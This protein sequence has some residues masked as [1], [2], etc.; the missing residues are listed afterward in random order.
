MTALGIV[1]AL[2]LFM[3]LPVSAAS[4]LTITPSAGRNIFTGTGSDQ[5]RYGSS[6]IIND[7]R[8]IDVWFAAPGSAQ[9]FSCWDSVRYRRSTDGG[10]T[11]TA[12]KKVLEGTRNADDQYSTCDPGVVKFGGY[13][14]IGYTSVVKSNYDAYHNETGNQVYIARSQN[15]DGPYEKWNGNGW[16]GNSP[17]AF[18]TYP[19]PTTSWGSGEPGFVVKDGTVYIYYTVNDATEGLMTKVATA[20]ATD[21]NWPGKVTQ[22]GTALRRVP[23]DDSAD[24][25]YIDDYNKFIAVYTSKRWTEDSYISTYLSDD[26]IH[27]SEIAY[28][29][30]N[31]NLQK[32]LHN[33]G[34]SGRADGHLRLSDSNFVI[35]A[36]GPGSPTIWNTYFTPV[37]FR[38]NTT[39]VSRNPG[40]SDP[41][42]SAAKTS[43]VSPGQNPA[44]STPANQNS[45]SPALSGQVTS[46]TSAEGDSA[47]APTDTEDT[48]SLETAESGADESAADESGGSADRDGKTANFLLP[49]IIIA[50]LILAAGSVTAVLLIRRSKKLKETPE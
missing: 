18:I 17:K 46:D 44:S 27:F 39:T 7:D 36:Y 3:A 40:T 5:Y 12:D 26:G 11:W 16:G 13:Y 20:P 4:T 49:L 37:S 43:S 33:M 47:G 50:A 45:A 21:A 30:N 41:E 28:F 25:K 10:K 1:L 48:D 34:I 23:G 9:G 35:Y 6:I 22:R 31:A 8:S 14:Y 2:A 29:E 42:S 24:V 19:I 38:Y 15:P 32:R